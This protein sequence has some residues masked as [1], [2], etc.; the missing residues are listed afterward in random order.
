MKIII[1]T[2]IS[3]SLS[4][5]LFLSDF[6]NMFELKAFDLFSQ[7]L[8]PSSA[9]GDIVIIKI[10]QQSIDFISRQGVTWPWPRQMYA[11]IIEYLSEADAIFLDI[12]FTEPSSYGVQDDLVFAESVKRA[13]NVYLPLFLTNKKSTISRE[14]LKFIKKIAINDRVPVGLIYN[15]A[16]T[17]IDPLKHEVIG[18]GNVTIPPDEDG[19]YRK[20]PLF[21]K[22]G[23]ITLPHFVMSYIMQKGKVKMQNGVLFINGKKVLLVE[24]RLMLRYYTNNS[25]F[26]EFSAVEIFQ[27]CLDIKDFK[28][29]LIQKE[30]FRGKKVF[31]GL[32][33]AGLYD[34]KPTSTSSISTGVLI[35][36]TTLDN[37]L[38]HNYIRP[39]QS[40]YTI[41]FLFL[42]CFFTSF[43]LMRYHS[44][45]VTLSILI[46]FLNI[47]IA[48]PAL[49]FKHSYY[50]NITSP[51]ISLIISFIFS[52]AYSYATEGKE[53]RF[54]KKIFSQYMDKNIVEYLLKNPHL[55]KPGGQRQWVTIFFADIAGFTSIA[56]KLTPEDIAKILHTTL[57]VFTDVIIEN[58]GVI[59]KYIGD[60]IMAFWGAPIKTEK[61]EINACQAALQCLESLGEINSNFRLEGLPEI[62]MRIGIHAGDAIVGNLGSDR[63]FDY[64]AVGDT[65]N[66][67]SRLESSNKLFKTNIIISEDV[68]QKTEEMF[69]VRELGMVEVKG[70]TIP[71]RIFELLSENTT[72]TEKQKQVVELYQKGLSLFRQQNYQEALY[73]FNTI[74]EKSP[75][76]GPTT[77]YRKRCEMLKEKPDLTFDWDI[78]KITEK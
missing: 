22:V 23:E 27:S 34:L 44:M 37:L 57:N 10:D 59:D 11:P 63:L 7:Y 62:R 55:I 5:I 14:D 24:Q 58:K 69:F 73:V 6:F 25:P 13:S 67:A 43:V 21:F 42:I 48:V 76:D 3:F 53:R 2:S 15:S 36:A 60:C 32:T 68:L 29:P 65:V 31:I 56:E 12:L 38:K 33:A 9:N 71:L 39:L 51:I 75:D 52:F 49:L 70:K 46:I 20:I 30:Y 17:P 50:M 1:L 61:D 54:I 47:T 66:I 74:L 18:S 8:N 26:H 41:A 40:S 72:V 28:K 4:L 64:T 35:H 16:I 19:V 45:Y 77:F 78:I